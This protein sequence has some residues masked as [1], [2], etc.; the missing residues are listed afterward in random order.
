MVR[1]WARLFL[2]GVRGPRPRKGDDLYRRLVA[3]PRAVYASAPARNPEW[4][5]DQ[6][7]KRRAEAGVKIYVIVYKEVRA[8]RERWLEFHLTD[9]GY[10]SVDVQLRAYQ[11]CFAEPLPRGHTRSWEYSCGPA[12]GP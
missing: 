4:R 1:R 7:L 12:S 8:L 9:A 6:I 5:L 2:G 11:T 3:V 10:P